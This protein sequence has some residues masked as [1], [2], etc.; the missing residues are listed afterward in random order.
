MFLQRKVIRT[1]SVEY[2]PFLLSLFLTLSAVMWFFYG[3]LIKDYNVAV[4]LSV[5]FFGDINTK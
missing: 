4:S 1:K 3:L 5:F 2:M